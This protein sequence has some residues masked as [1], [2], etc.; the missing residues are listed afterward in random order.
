[1]RKGSRNIW[2]AAPFRRKRISRQESRMDIDKLLKKKLD[3]IDEEPEN[4]EEDDSVLEKP[5]IVMSSKKVKWI[6]LKEKISMGWIFMPGRF[7][8]KESYVLFTTAF[9]PKG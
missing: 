8:F 9:S 5:E 3:T 7:S 1:M 2:W 6:R 4:I